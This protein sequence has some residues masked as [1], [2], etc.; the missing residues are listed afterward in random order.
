MAISL[1]SIKISK[2]GAYRM[3]IYSLAGIGKTTLAAKINNNI[4]AATQQG[5]GS[6]EQ[7]HWDVNT[8]QDMIDI[9]GVLYNDSHN[10][11]TL[12]V[13]MVTEFETILHNKLLKDEGAA[14][15]EDV[16]GG[17]SKWLL[18]ALPLW[19]TIF[20]GLEALRRDR[21]MNIILLGHAVDKKETPP[22]MEP[23][24]KYTLSLL[25]KHIPTLI[26][27]WVDCICFYHQEVLTKTVKGSNKKDPKMQAAKIKRVMHLAEQPYAYAKNR[28][29]DDPNKIEMTPDC[30][31]FL[32]LFGFNS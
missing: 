26:Y 16:G 31:E 22:N 4:F 12:T 3:L 29:F 15:L 32:N 20:D 13:D 2:V 8:Y 10:F 23:Y 14:T 21:G 1:D 6:R 28:Y 27:G 7:P 18:Q 24:N 5:F 30:S 19:H 11:T 25:N 9:I 17:W